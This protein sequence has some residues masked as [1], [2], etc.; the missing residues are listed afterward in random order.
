MSDN[1]LVNKWGI[2]FYV[3]KSSNK[4]LCENGHKMIER[5]N[6]HFHM[7]QTYTDDNQKGP[8][9]EKHQKCN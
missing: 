6:F 8:Q 5:G 7:P 1:A 9:R 3:N 4:K 2:F